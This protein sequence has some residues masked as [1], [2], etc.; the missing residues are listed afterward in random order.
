MDKTGG[1]YSQAWAKTV[2]TGAGIVLYP[3][4]GHGGSKWYPRN[5]GCEEVQLIQV[6][7]SR[8]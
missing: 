1:K 4:E 6:K 7:Q 3:G 8:C 5:P 2:N